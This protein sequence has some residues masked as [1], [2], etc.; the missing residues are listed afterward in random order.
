MIDVEIHLDQNFDPRMYALIFSPHPQWSRPGSVEGLRLTNIRDSIL[1]ENAEKALKYISPGQYVPYASYL[2]SILDQ[3][4]YHPNMVSIYNHIL[5]VVEILKGKEKKITL[6]LLEKKIKHISEG[7]RLSFSNFILVGHHFTNETNVYS[8]QDFFKKYILNLDLKK[9]DYYKFHEYMELIEKD[10]PVVKI[11]KSIIDNSNLGKNT[12]VS[13]LGYL[14]NKGEVS[15][16][17]ILESQKLTFW[18]KIQISLWF[19]LSDDLKDSFKN[20]YIHADEATPQDVYN[21]LLFFERNTTH[22]L[23]DASKMKD[24]LLR[25]ILK[26]EFKERGKIALIPGSKALKK[27]LGKEYQVF[28]QRLKELSSD[29]KLDT[30][31]KARHYLLMSLS[32]LEQDLMLKEWSKEDVANP[33]SNLCQSICKLADS[34]PKWGLSISKDN[35]ESSLQENNSKGVSLILG[36]YFFN[37]AKNICKSLKAPREVDKLEHAVMEGLLGDEVHDCTTCSGDITLEAGLDKLN[38]VTLTKMLFQIK[39]HVKNGGSYEERFSKIFTILFLDQISNRHTKISEKILKRKKEVQDALSRPF[40]NHNSFELPFFYGVLG[41]KITNI[42]NIPSINRSV[43]QNK[44]VGYSVGSSPSAVGESA[45]R[46]PGIFLTLNLLNLSGGKSQ[47]NE[48]KIIES[49][50]N[51]LKQYEELRLDL[52]NKGSH[53]GISSYHIGFYLVALLQSAQTL[54]YLRLKFGDK[55]NLLKRLESLRSRLKNKILEDI[56]PYG[57]LKSP[58]GGFSLLSPAAA[59]SLIGL[60]MLSLLKKGQCDGLPQKVLFPTY[61][62]STLNLK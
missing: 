43:Q 31:K 8:I 53:R 24:L 45:A 16:K 54:N 52:S 38:R 60:S 30:R 50:E 12:Y 3:D 47:R 33:G 15:N 48:D 18:E 27:A 10:I 44:A 4:F 20:W 57:T 17:E 59:N 56:S 62:Q 36:L 29:P 42:F 34:Y 26:T 49:I 25:L 41:N 22:E 40:Q 11:T 14:A 28:I 21:F 5:G 37:Y 51:V 23:K 6:D 7:S 2:I 39:Q 35:Q 1:Q 32:P 55:E 46:M 9:S 13:M 61:L 19:N 58:E